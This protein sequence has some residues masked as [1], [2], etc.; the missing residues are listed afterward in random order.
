MEFE[1][2]EHEPIAA[3]SFRN[4]RVGN[5]HYVDSLTSGENA[6]FV[7]FSHGRIVGMAA[8]RNGRI[9]LLYVDGAFHRQGIATAL[10]RDM[11]CVLKLKGHNEIFLDSSPSG[12]PFCQHFGFSQIGEARNER[13]GI[14]T[15]MAYEPNEIWDVLDEHGNKTGRYAERGRK[16]ATGDYFLIV[17]VWK[18]N[19]KGEWLI[20][21]RTPRY[22]NGDL[23]GKWETTG[24]CAVAGED[25]LSAA[26]RETR[27]ELGIELDPGKGMLL[28]R[29]PRLGDNGHTWFEDVWVFNY[30]EPIEAIAYD[31]SEVCNAIWATIGRIREMMATGEFVN[32]SLYP[33]FDEMVE[34]YE[35]AK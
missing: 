27:E 31:G 4:D 16:M 8:E 23:D 24:G 19:T 14:V 26:L 1:A 20:D 21:Q 22:G 15:P 10:V 17:H 33:Y 18:R 28:K 35:T 32:A 13:G 29:T 7:A 9:W 6:M 3:V 34:R 30:D 11:V 2:P 25:S 12:L 5:Q